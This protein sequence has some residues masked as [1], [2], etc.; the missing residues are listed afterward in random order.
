MYQEQATRLAFTA[1]DNDGWFFDGSTWQPSGCCG[2]GNW[3]DADTGNPTYALLARSPSYAKLQAL[4][5]SGTSQ[6]PPLN[7]STDCPV[8]RARYFFNSFK[9]CKTSPIRAWML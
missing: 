5:S 1:P 6:G 8:A 9:R 4:D 7:L 3:S 2:D